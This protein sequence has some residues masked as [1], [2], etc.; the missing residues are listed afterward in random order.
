[1]TTPSGTITASTCLGA[2]SIS[3]NPTETMSWPVLLSIASNMVEQSC[4]SSVAGLASLAGGGAPSLGLA[5]IVILS[6]SLTHCVDFLASLPAS[7]AASLAAGAA[8]GAA[9]AGALSC[10][11]AGRPATISANPAA[12][13][14]AATRWN[15]QTAYVMEYINLSP[16]AGPN[17]LGPTACRACVGAPVRCPLASSTG[18]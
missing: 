15:R 10:A 9:G 12:V 13:Q 18:Q 7:L 2:P 11:E 8:P 14:S 6:Q 3:C 16:R 1:M 4:L 5:L 17:Q